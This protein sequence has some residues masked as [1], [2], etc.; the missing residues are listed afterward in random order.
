MRE[1]GHAACRRKKHEPQ[2]RLQ[3]W[4]GDD[5]A[6]R[7]YSFM[8]FVLLSIPCVMTLSALLRLYGRS[9]MWMSVGI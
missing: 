3:L 4:E 6:L 8:V 5:A 2:P 7:A 1:G 9:M